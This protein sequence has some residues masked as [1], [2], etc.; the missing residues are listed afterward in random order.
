MYT[1]VAPISVFWDAI[2]RL[3]E[4]V[5]AVP[6]GN[7]GDVLRAFHSV[8]ADRFHLQVLLG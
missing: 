1:Y 4:Q 2:L 5:L 7:R 3:T 8:S 6:D